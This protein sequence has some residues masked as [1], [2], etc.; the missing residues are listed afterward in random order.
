MGWGEGG[1]RDHLSALRNGNISEWQSAWQKLAPEILAADTIILGDS[2]P[3]LRLTPRKPSTAS[4]IAALFQHKPTL[5]EVLTK[6]QQ[7]L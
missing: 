4:K 7:Q 3:R 5:E 1:G 6:L 2:R